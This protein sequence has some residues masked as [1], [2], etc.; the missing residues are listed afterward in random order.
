MNL[1]VHDDHFTYPI[2]TSKANFLD[3]T[4]LF[5]NNDDDNTGTAVKTRELTFFRVKRS[6]NLNK[7][8]I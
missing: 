1:R 8:H 4:L 3:A 2:F 7:H 6:S 5:D